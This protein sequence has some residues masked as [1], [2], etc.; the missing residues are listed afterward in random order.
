[1][2]TALVTILGLVALVSC[3]TE[4][5]RYD[6]LTAAQQ[7]IIR[8]R[9]TQL[10]L[11][12]YTSVFDRWKTSSN[13]IYSS[14]NFERG[15]GYYY[16]QKKDSADERLIDI[17]VWKQTATEIY[18]YIKDSRAGSNYFLR[19]TKTVNDAMIADMLEA[20]CARGTSRLYV[21][22]TVANNGPASFTYE[23]EFP[24]DP[25]DEVYTDVYSMSFSYPAYF[26]GFQIQRTAKQLD[27]DDRQVGNSVNYTSSLT[28]KGVTFSS[29]NY[30]DYTQKFCIPVV[31]STTLNYQFTNRR[32]QE[33]F[34][35]NLDD[36]AQC[37]TT[38]AAAQAAGWDLSI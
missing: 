22:S 9:G 32:S 20:H 5:G 34:Y 7:E 24:G 37:L 16:V 3:Q 17:Q 10:C 36:T 25:T 21:R 12:E 23:H 8:N 14:S 18:F 6:K 31:D 19:L 15:D 38:Y 27:D 13:G 28:F 26:A 35:I 2:K 11:N 29:N 4:E 1:M 30:A 33:G